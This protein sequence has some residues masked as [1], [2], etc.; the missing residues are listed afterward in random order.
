MTGVVAMLAIAA[1]PA[2][3]QFDDLPAP[4]NVNDPVSIYDDTE[5]AGSQAS[6]SPADDGADETT[7]NGITDT[8]EV[9]ASPSDEIPQPRDPA[10]ESIPQPL[11][12][13]RP[14][15]TD[16]RNADSANGNWETASGENFAG[17][18]RGDIR[19]AQ[20][21]M[22]LHFQLP[23]TSWTR[24]GNVVLPSWIHAASPVS[25]ALPVPG[26]RGEEVLPP[27]QNAGAFP[28]RTGNMGE[29]P[30]AVDTL[31]HQP[32]MEPIFGRMALGHH[33]RRLRWGDRF[34]QSRLDDYG[35]GV[36]RLDDA[37]FEMDTVR[38]WNN[39]HFRFASAKRYQTPDRVEYFWGKSPDGRGPSNLTSSAEAFVDYQDLR[40]R[41]EIGGSRMSV[42]TELPIRFL[43]PVINSNTA[44]LGDMSL[45]TKTVLMGGDT[46]QLT[47]VFRNYF[48]TGAVSHGL[49]TGHV[50][51]EPGFIVRYRPR[52][53]L[54]LTGELK[55]WFPIGADP[56]HSGQILR[57]G[58]GASR[59]AFENDQ[60][61]WLPTLEVVAFSVMDG[62]K[63]VRD[64]TTGLPIVTDID[65][66]TIVNIYPG[67]WFV[68]E[69]GSKIDIG[70]SSGISVTGNR[71]YDSIFRLDVRYS[72]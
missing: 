67:M 24:R 64:T 22:E 11:G 18:T 53:R 13:V 63:S 38:T 14:P 2:W 17:L 7:S 29:D 30:I 69:Y 49:G 19:T 59:V 34:R 15:D 65:G 16:A 72:Y 35:L 50:S 4:P 62:Q 23:Q 70:V 5:D 9:A 12:N 3:A 27:P 47:Q 52:P 66:E 32:I 44:G 1:A 26:D 43:D 60:F 71:F 56:T 61:A 33:G 39:F 48:N 46:W 6:T 58:L 55:Y 68:S 54:S 57:Y 42:Q 45:A 25:A 41:T 40:I 31:P 10:T 21:P 37:L 20:P 51:M 36:E 28:E 8:E